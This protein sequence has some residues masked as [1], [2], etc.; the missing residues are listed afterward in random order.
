VENRLL[1]SPSSDG[2]S[3]F[4]ARLFVAA[5]VGSLHGEKKR[6]RRRRTDTVNVNIH[7]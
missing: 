7:G 5:V 3:Q 2:G 1:C 4:V 6:R